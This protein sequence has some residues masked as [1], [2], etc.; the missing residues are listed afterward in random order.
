MPRRPGEPVAS[1]RFWKVGELAERTGLTVRTLHHYGAMGLLSPSGRTDS[2][3]G[4]GHRLYSAS[5]VARLQQITS[6][7]LLGFGLEQIRDHLDRSDYDPRQVV[8]LHLDRIR[9]QVAELKRLEGRLT[10]LA[11]ALD[12]AEVV[13]ADAFLT[14]IEGMTMIEK[15]YTPEQMEYL[16]QR[17]QEVGEEVIQQAP[18]PWAELQVEVKTAMDAGLDPT[19]PQAA[20]L[21]RRWF[22]LIT[23]FTGGDPG[24]FKSLGRMYQNED[25]IRGMDVAALRPM[26]DWISKASKAAGVKHPG[27]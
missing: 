10:A 13:S 17:R 27:T 5:D 7:K 22:A 6:L 23:A 18:N 26:M 19:A 11:D 3:H 9:G 25:T 12:K 16:N 2:A 1:A 15:Y 21:A 20:E 14:T 8:R 24:I 4:A